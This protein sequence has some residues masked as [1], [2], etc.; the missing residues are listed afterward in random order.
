MSPALTVVLPTLEAAPATSRRGMLYGWVT[1]I[2]AYGMLLAIGNR[3]V[4][5][6][7]SPYRRQTMPLP[8]P[9]Y[10]PAAPNRRAVAPPAVPLRHPPCRCATRHAAA[11]PAVPL[12]Q[13]PRA[14]R[15]APAHQPAWPR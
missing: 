2:S 14:T 11:P 1:T 4:E 3:R 15:R 9:R 6:R 8:P 13:S 5:A 7:A 12:R 10:S